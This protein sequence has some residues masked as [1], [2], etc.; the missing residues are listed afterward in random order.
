MKI[1]LTP[2]KDSKRASEPLGTSGLAEV[3]RFA[4]G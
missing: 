1:I 2:A 4:V 3:L